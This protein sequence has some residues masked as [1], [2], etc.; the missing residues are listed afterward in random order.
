MDKKEQKK[1]SRRKF[2]R[3]SSKMT[4]AGTAAAA[5][6]GLGALPTRVQ[7]MCTGCEGT[8]SGT[9][10]EGCIDGCSGSCSGDCVGHRKAGLARSETTRCG[11]PV[12]QQEISNE[13][14]VA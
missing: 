4:L 10:Y 7:A 14:L 6:L 12:L 13:H 11:T 8:C 2:L 5:F 3:D 1:A 9:C